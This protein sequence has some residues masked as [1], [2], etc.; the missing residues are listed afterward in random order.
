[1]RKPLV[2]ANWKMHGSRQL[3]TA[4][5]PTLAAKLGALDI[6]VVLL[7]PAV[8][9]ATAAELL[10]GENVPS[11]TIALGAQN[12][13]PEAEGAF[14]GEISAAMLRDIGCRYALAGHSERRSLFGES[15]QLV[16]YK[17]KAA[18]DAG[19]IAILCV[20]ESL[21][22]RESDKTLAV[23]RRQLGAVIEV[24]G[25]A[26]VAK[27]IIA[28]EPVWAIGTGKTATPQQAQEVH[29]ALRQELG[30]AG[31]ETR[32]LYGG[33]IKA[34]NAQALFSQPDIDGGLVGGASLNAEEFAKIC[35]MAHTK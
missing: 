11:S 18:Q 13:S 7:P 14:T 4:Y 15:D 12:L 23:V 26:A 19:L 34:D 33:S 29:F 9:L 21:A 27:A 3:V 22:E 10:S 16:A 32:I 24:V 30:N 1:M 28:Y 20:G 17:F 8:F 25:L 5:I 31:Q 35:A 6:D 2:A